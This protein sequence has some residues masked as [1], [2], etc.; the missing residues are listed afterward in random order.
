VQLDK[1]T[2]K[3]RMPIWEPKYSAKWEGKDEEVW[4]LKDKVD[5]ARTPHLQIFFTKTK[6]E[7][8]EGNW[9]MSVRAAKKYPIGWNGTG[10]CYKVPFNHLV[11]LTINERD[12]RALI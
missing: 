6:A 1:Y 4:L 10:K 5:H 7:K 9:Y 2:P 3:T 11:P 12:L 8:Y